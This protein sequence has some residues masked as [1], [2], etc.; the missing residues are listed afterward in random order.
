MSGDVE[1]AYRGGLT[2]EAY[3]AR[4][5]VHLH[6]FND[7]YER[8]A[9][10]REHAAGKAPLGACRILILTEDYCIDSVLNVPLIAHL[11]EATPDAELRI[12]SRDM[13][14]GLARCFPGRGDMS[15]LPTVI[16]LRRSMQVLGYWSERS[17]SD[18]AW[19]ATFQARHPIP[20]LTL[21]NGQPRGAPVDW[22]ARRLASQRP[23]FESQ[24]WRDVRNELHAIASAD[25]PTD[26]LTPA[27]P[28]A[29]A[30]INE[31]D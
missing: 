22:M 18:H 13:Y 16:F 12:A 1:Q 3:R 28:V 6:A 9:F 31:N 19:M 23:F 20:A 10:V 26:R 24:S 4:M 8:L 17:K 15:R 14:A 7:L 5:R 30:S 21:D 11:A 27:S 25:S 2:F 29:L